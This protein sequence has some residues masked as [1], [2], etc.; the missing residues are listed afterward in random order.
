[1]N[2]LLPVLL[3]VSIVCITV[4]SLVL[5]YLLAM[6]KTLRSLILSS[7]KLVEIEDIIILCHPKMLKNGYVD[8]LERDEYKLAILQT[9]LLLTKYFLQVVDSRSMFKSPKKILDRLLTEE[10]ERGKHEHH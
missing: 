10:K 8:Q 9:Y 3:L 7:E 4:S 5:G 2:N 1:M 6:G